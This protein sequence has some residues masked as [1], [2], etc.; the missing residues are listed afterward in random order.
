MARPRWTPWLC[1]ALAALCAAVVVAPAP[2]KAQMT[3]PHWV[4]RTRTA[5]PSPE[6][7][8]LNIEL[9]AQ[10]WKL[11]T[12][13]RYFEA[14]SA[15]ERLLELRQ[16][17]LGPEHLETLFAATWAAV[18]HRKVA[19]YHRAASL[20][21][22]VVA[23]LERDGVPAWWFFHEQDA[24][25]RA[26][27]EMGD[28][29]RAE[30][31]YRRLLA[32]Q[33]LEGNSVD[34]VL[35]GLA[36][37]AKAQGDLDRAA[38]LYERLLATQEK[39][40]ARR[41]SAGAKVDAAELG[42]ALDN[43]AEVYRLKGS[44][45]RA[46]ALFRRA[47]SILEPWSGGP[48]R[49]L[50]TCLDHQALL[51]RDMGDDARAEPL[52]ERALAIREKKL[53]PTDPDIAEPLVHLGALYWDRQQY[54]RAQASFQRALSLLQQ[55][56]G[57]E[58]PRV[59]E[60][61]SS[62]EGIAVAQ[63][64]LREALSMRL[65]AVSAEDRHLTRLLTSGA[66]REKLAFLGRLERSTSETISLHAISAPKNDEAAALALTT[67]LRR[68]ARALDATAGSLASLRRSMTRQ[69]QALLDRLGAIDAELS[70]RAYRDPPGQRARVQALVEE[71]EG[72]EAEV[73]RRSA[74]FRAEQRPVLLAE[75]QAAIPDDA[76]LIELF[77]YRPYQPRARQ[78][79]RLGEPRYVAYV[80]RPTGAPAF[81][82]LGEVKAIDAAVEELRRALS[83]PSRDPTRLA[84]GVDAQLM[85][86]VRPLL[87]PAR[88]LLIS[89]DGALS[90]L[91]FGALIDEDQRSLLE[92]YEITY[93]TTGRDLLR[94]TAPA[95]PGQELVVI[96]DPAFDGGASDG[97]APATPFGKQPCGWDCEAQ[98]GVDLSRLRFLPLPGTAKEAAAVGAKLTGARVLTGASATEGA[99][100]GLARPRVLHI[101]THGFF[102]PAA[103]APRQA[104]A[105]HGLDAVD[106]AAVAASVSEVDSALLRSGLAFAGAN[107]RES[108]GDDGVLTAAEVTGLDLS[109]T[110]L[111]VL[112]ACDTG[113]GEPS[114]GEGVQGLRRAL[115]IAGAE[116]Q[117]MS[118]WRIGDQ[119]TR[120]LMTAYYDRLVA[121]RARS[122]A[123]REAQLSLKG[124]PDTAHP[125]YWA[126][127]IV[128]G[129]GGPLRGGP[130]QSAA[131]KPQTD[132]VA[133]VRPGPRGCACEVQG[134][135]AGGAPRLDLA[136]GLAAGLAAAALR[137]RA[138]SRAARRSAKAG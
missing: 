31:L 14:L 58:H 61:A 66:E 28:F 117:V 133:P 19:E 114:H 60:C 71:R 46:E 13:G 102:L 25:A 110:Q 136:A 10:L 111:V 39:E 57:P 56:L 94:L 26:Y 109:G 3:Q 36:A 30:A 62:L 105:R 17:V 11:T 74:A 125:Y 98:R 40:N 23:V 99:V 9:D 106:R 50:A 127:F 79:D 21:E 6:E 89:P 16:R 52:F 63:G 124:Q 90:L 20:L 120:H 104:P 128:S 138:G 86:K 122:E 82:D 85:A 87:G 53:R 132:P 34:E 1:G 47:V 92:R 5:L 8:R 54:G 112:S 48:E 42:V 121:G 84:R 18:H 137:R 51:Y 44:H 55:A 134:G 126:A 78:R 91:P 123:L 38:S 107:L 27:R 15:A 22:H 83:D 4:P 24:L 101:A 7:E 116:T 131:P 32:E 135:A 103:P 88:K 29:R 59:A 75:V 96:A 97:G 37:L 12:E 73:S 76:A 80:L 33:V 118:L 67:I 41:R 119:A 69:D 108:G 49:S 115:V 129:N 93:L 72:I 68:K 130:L 45:T 95:E 35:L 81:A 65:A 64:K 70:A 113:V 2:A 43:L 77:A 100:K